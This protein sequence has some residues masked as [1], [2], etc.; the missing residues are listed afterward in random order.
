MVDQAARQRARRAAVDA[1]ARARRAR[2]ERDRRL[3]TAGVEVAVALAERDAL[4]AGFEAQA[5]AALAR[6]VAEGL[7]V[8]AAAAWCGYDGLTRAEAVRLLRVARTDVDTD[9]GGIRS[10]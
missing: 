7:T 5:G 2:A 8:A 9:S 10:S 6:M 1:Q 3:D 4:A